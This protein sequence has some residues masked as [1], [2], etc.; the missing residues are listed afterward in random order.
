MVRKEWVKLPSG[1]IEDG[2]LRSLRWGGPEGAGANN[3]AALMTLI[4]LAHHADDENGLIKLTYD[5]LEELT[6]LSRPKVSKGLDGLEALKIID[7]DQGRSIYR[8]LGYNPKSGWAKLPCKALYSGMRIAAFHEFR[9][10]SMAELNALKL[11]LLFAARRG[12]DTNMANISYDKITEYTGIERPRIK[13]AQSLLAIHNMAHVER[14]PSSTNDI[15]V[16][17]AYRLVGLDSYNHMGTKGRGL[18]PASLSAEFS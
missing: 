11:Y 6:G 14:L 2:G 3:I 17:N 9:L 10:R 5:Q 7:R 18:D 1:W 15:G 12:R 4:A 16:S 13:A 8:L